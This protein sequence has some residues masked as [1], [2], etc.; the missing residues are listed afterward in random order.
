ML[1]AMATGGA[2][3]VH[4]DDCATA[5][6]I[7]EGVVSGN[8]TL[9]LTQFQ[10]GCGFEA[11]FTHDMWYVH[12]PLHTGHLTATFGCD[13]AGFDTG[14]F[15]YKGSCDGLQLIGCNDDSCG[16]LSALTVPVEAGEPVFI[17][18][19]GLEPSSFGSFTMKVSTTPSPPVFDP[20]IVLGQ[21]LVG[22]DLGGFTGPIQGGDEFG[23]VAIVG[24]LDLD[25]VPDLAVGAALDDDGSKDAGA[26]WMLHLH[27]DGSVKSQLKVSRLS[28]GFAG[29]IGTNDQFGAAV[30]GL[31]DLDGDGT[32]D[33][34]VGSPTDSDVFFFSGAVWVLFLNPDGSVKDQ[35]KIGQSAGGFGGVLHAQDRFG[36]GVAGLGDVDGDGIPDLAVGAEQDNDFAVNAGAV[37]ILFMNRDGTVRTQQK[38]SATAGG[39]GFPLEEV[40]WFGSS[41]ASAGDVNGDGVPDLAVGAPLSNTEETGLLWLLFLR[42]D[43]TVKE[44][45]PIGPSHGGFTLEL[46]DGA[47][48][49][50][51]VTGIGDL[52]ADGVPDLAVGAPDHKFPGSGTVSP[53]AIAL[54]FLR[55]DGTLKKQRLIDGSTENL[56]D[57][58]RLGSA[59]TSPGDLD[60][61]GRLDL[62][63]GERVPV[64]P[65][66]KLRTLF[67]DAANPWTFTAG[68]LAGI[69]GFP[70]LTGSGSLVPSSPTTLSLASAAPHSHATLFIGFSLLNA[71]FLGGL[72]VPA[73]DLVMTGLATDARGRLDVSGIWPDGLPEQF[74]VWFQIWTTDAAGL[75]GFSAS[76]GLVGTTP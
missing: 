32:P 22:M 54:L 45:L 73:R 38:I 62:I 68:A 56:G 7:P 11:P 12:V 23:E 18:V 29:D 21:T 48:F 67:L 40:G 37:W 49:G 39:F 25:G 51:S 30:A 75:K 64:F 41:V 65:T 74:P 70:V 47:H 50:E 69:D 20:H 46:S 61:D 76:N 72:L 10:T 4:N 63:A 60:G 17:V 57:T 6:L 31:G 36:G 19:S 33:L 8:N 58:G 1:V 15:M 44:A 34:A 27:A 16:L 3:Q 71:P 2:A 24:D 26:V 9:A 28:G 35:R 43:G 13:G 52:D 14:L 5:W 55:A 42:S 66:D 59:L 53:G